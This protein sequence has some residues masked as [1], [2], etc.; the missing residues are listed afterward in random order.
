[1]GF[2]LSFDL[3]FMSLS[4]VCAE[5]S[6]REGPGFDTGPVV[7]SDNDLSMAQ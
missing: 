6:G 2:A 7:W 1:M 4:Q 3:T 5:R